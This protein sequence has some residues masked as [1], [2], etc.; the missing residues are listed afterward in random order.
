MV[1]TRPA[2][3]IGQSEY[4][5]IQRSRYDEAYPRSWAFPG[6]KIEKGEDPFPAACREIN[7]E[8]GV[9][10]TG[11][12]YAMWQTCCITQMKSPTHEYKFYAFQRDTEPAR[13]KL[14]DSAISGIGWFGIEQLATMLL[15][16]ST[17]L[18]IGGDWRSVSS[19]EQ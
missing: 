8:I 3:R 16:P 17:N 11:R 14:A 4:L 7:E 19:K 2:V 9:E 18:I 6:G 13:F 5:L 1:L 12:D 10:I 15:A